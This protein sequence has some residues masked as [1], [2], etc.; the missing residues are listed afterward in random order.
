ML[1]SSPRL[2]IIQSQTSILLS[3]HQ[4]ISKELPKHTCSLYFLISS[5]HPHPD[6]NWVSPPASWNKFFTLFGICSFLCLSIQ[7]FISFK[8]WRV[9][10][11]VSLHS[12]LSWRSINPNICYLPSCY[13]CYS[14]STLAHLSLLITVTIFH[15]HRMS[16]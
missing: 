16:L 9:R 13:F 12:W 3:F 5:N 4:I 7:F 8:L 1:S 2:S 6:D 11:G 10:L 14:S 15:S